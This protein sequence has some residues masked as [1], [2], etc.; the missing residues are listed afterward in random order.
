MSTCI[1]TH[2]DIY[3]LTST[4]ASSIMNLR[5]AFEDDYE[6]VEMLQFH[7]VKVRP[8]TP[9]YLDANPYTCK[10]TVIFAVFK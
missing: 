9:S 6:D 7:L 2:N 4:G 10:C 5:K 8:H 3:M 1:L